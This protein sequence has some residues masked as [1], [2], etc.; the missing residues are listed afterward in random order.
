MDDTSLGVWHNNCPTAQPN[1]MPWPPLQPPAT[2]ATRPEPRPWEPPAALCT[3]CA[4]V[5]ARGSATSVEPAQCY[6]LSEA[7]QR[8]TPLSA[9][10][11]P[12]AGVALHRPLGAPTA[13][14]P[15]FHFSTYFG[16]N[17]MFTGLFPITSLSE[18]QHALNKNRQGNL[19]LIC[20]WEEKFQGAWDAAL[21]VPCTHRPA[22]TREG[23][24]S[25]FVDVLHQKP[26]KQP[27]DPLTQ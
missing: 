16:C 4:L 17:Y 26:Y 15:D 12:G 7:P 5:P 19:K 6:L 8:A 11:S 18:I 24:P 20:H 9:P 25:S 23:L 2:P 3:G 13:G 1:Q 21:P 14:C 22:G 10:P 27:D